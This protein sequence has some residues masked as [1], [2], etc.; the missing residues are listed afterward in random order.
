MICS[1]TPH[2]LTTHRRYGGDLLAR[3]ALQPDTRHR[4]AIAGAPTADRVRLDVYP[5][6]G[7]AR[8]RVFGMPTRAARQALA[9]R[10]LQLLPTPQLGDVLGA[11][12]LTAGQAARWA[13]SRPGPAGLPPSVRERFGLG[14]ATRSS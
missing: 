11:A 4:F 13:Q 6:G 9:A 3:T 14:P 5:D 12:G 7:M 10:F 1:S 2:V 8:L